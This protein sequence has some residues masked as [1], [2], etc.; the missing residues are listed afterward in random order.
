MALSKGELLNILTEEAKSHRDYAYKSLKRNKHMN[1]LS[2]ADIR[3]LNRLDA[4]FR[5]RLIDAVL[6]D[7]INY[8]AAGQGVDYGLYTKH[9]LQ[10]GG[11]G[12]KP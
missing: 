6:V 10:D 8:L 1:D 2:P 11:K 9:L 7:Y 4:G 5:Q 12:E 3:E